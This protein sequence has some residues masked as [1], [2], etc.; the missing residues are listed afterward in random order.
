MR[1]SSRLAV[2]LT[3]AAS[4]AAGPAFALDPPSRA[5][6][7]VA[8]DI[9]RPPALVPLPLPTPFRGFHNHAPA[10]S[11]ADFPTRLKALE[12]AAAKDHLGAQWTLGR[13]Y[14]DGDEVPR[15]DYKA[16]QYFSR[17]ANDHA[18]DRPES[19]LARYVASAFVALGQY[20]LV[21][22]PNTSVKV[23]PVRAREMFW[24]AASYFGDTNAQYDLARMYLD[25]AADMTPE[26]RQAARWLDLAARKGHY[27]AQAVLGHLLIKGG[28]GVPRQ[29]AR[30]LMYLT[31]AREGA[32]ADQKWV[33]DLY[34]AAMRIASEDERA[35]ALRYLERYISRPE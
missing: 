25:G 21:G 22:I 10:Q 29:I 17:V 27:Q 9:P 6:P 35:L 1:T 32:G 28:K 8:L 34:D 12:Y 11:E 20:Y 2:L 15:D 33:V 31:L 4:V 13:I 24:Y 3:I 23:D 26:P 5:L 19:P 14:A 16:F 18:D 30:G 7:P